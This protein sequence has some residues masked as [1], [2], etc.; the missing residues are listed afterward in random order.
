M[1]K[2][3]VVFLLAFLFQTGVGH[4]K[5]DLTEV[6]AFRI[7]NGGSQN[8]EAIFIM[9]SE[10]E[11]IV[12]SRVAVESV[13]VLTDTGAISFGSFSFRAF[14]KTD[15]MVVIHDVWN[16]NKK[17][18]RS[19]LRG[20]IGTETTIGYVKPVGRY[21]SRRSRSL[22]GKTSFRF[23]GLTGHVD[24]YNLSNGKRIKSVTDNKFSRNGDMLFVTTSD[25][26]GR[27]YGN[28]G[29][30]EVD[31]F[32]DHAS[33]VFLETTLGGSKQV[34]IVQKRWNTKHDGFECTH[35]RNTLAPN[36]LS[37][38]TELIRSIFAGVAKPQ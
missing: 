25:N 31:V 8:G 13:A 4:A 26:S 9:T 28:A 11:G 1:L 29:S 14:G 33:I 22:S 15:S 35:I 38:D 16:D 10:R 27:M 34:T 3:I 20:E 2:R 32:R 6:K 5:P 30:T 23:Y 17:G 37:G 18:F 19:V 36:F 21:D 24:V 12:S 7:Y